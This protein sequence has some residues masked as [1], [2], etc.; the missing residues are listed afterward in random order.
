MGSLLNWMLF[1]HLNRIIFSS[2]HYLEP[3][4]NCSTSLHLPCVHGPTACG[5]RWPQSTL[6]LL[7][8]ICSLLCTICSLLCTICSLLCTICS[9]LC[10][11]CSL[12]CTI[13]SLLCTICS[14]FCAICSLLC[15]IYSLLCTICLRKKG[16]GEEKTLY[17][18]ATVVAYFYRISLFLISL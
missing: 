6:S 5:V 11:I 12:L 16:C 7:C 3:F 10:T 2:F 18:G 14:L 4:N 17:F 13:C 8:T 15:T 1:S 9:L